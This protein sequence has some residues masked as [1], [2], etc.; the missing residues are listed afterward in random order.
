MHTADKATARPWRVMAEEMTGWTLSAED[1]RDICERIRRG[2]A[3]EAREARLREALEAAGN[4]LG[5]CAA[6][7]CDPRFTDRH[8]DGARCK[9]AVA[10]ARAAL[11]GKEGAA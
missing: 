9:R 5:M 10:R 2:E 1:A 11:A 4:E 6:V 3:A 8:D 7:F